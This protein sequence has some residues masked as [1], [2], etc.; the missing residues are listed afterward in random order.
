[1][2][3][4]NTVEKVIKRQSE[5]DRLRQALIQLEEDQKQAD[6]GYDSDENKQKITKAQ[7][8]YNEIKKASIRLDKD[9]KYVIDMDNADD[10]RIL[11]FTNDAKLP[12]IRQIRISKP[13]EAVD[14]N[15]EK[16]LNNSVSQ[17]LQLFCF[18]WNDKNRVNIKNYIDLFVPIIKKT[19]KEVFIQH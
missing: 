8:K 11:K 7:E 13:S 2:K 10:H 17:S 1:M 6:A 12:E 16:F 5:V 15:L 4:S 3:N 19:T 14:L 9:F 18:N